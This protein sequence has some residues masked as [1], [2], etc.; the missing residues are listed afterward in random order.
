MSGSQDSGLI[1]CFVV[2]ARSSICSSYLPRIRGHQYWLNFAW[3]FSAWSF[4][5]VCERH[6]L[7][8]TFQLTLGS[9]WLEVNGVG[10]CGL[11]G[12]NGGIDVLIS[13]SVFLI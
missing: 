10:S 4:I 2:H 7:R 8:F 6:P 12:S 5:R 1:L 11:M 3:T 9:Y 13:W